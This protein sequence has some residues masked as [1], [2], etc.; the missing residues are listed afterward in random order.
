MQ[1]IP[2]QKIKG[3]EEEIKT[4]K[5][6]GQKKT[7]KNGGKDFLY[8]ILKGVK[9]KVSEKDFEDAEKALFPHIK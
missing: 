8:G 7:V 5:S 1:Q 6:L 2:W 4:L 9:I 3:P